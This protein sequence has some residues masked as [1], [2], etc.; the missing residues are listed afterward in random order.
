MFLEMMIVLMNKRESNKLISF[1]LYF[2]VN[3]QTTLLCQMLGL[4]D[5]FAVF[6]GQSSAENPDEINLDDCSD[7][8]DQEIEES[9]TEL[10]TSNT[11]D[12]PTFIHSNTIN[13]ENLL[14]SSSVSQLDPGTPKIVE[15]A[16]PDSQ[17]DDEQVSNRKRMSTDEDN[18]PQ[19]VHT[20]LFIFG[21]TYYMLQCSTIV[22]I[23][24][25]FEGCW[26]CI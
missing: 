4:T 15:K 11:E 25:Y 19:V 14:S 18:K 23:L 16:T 21:C 13:D 17:I 3:P 9:T 26:S 22:E 6:S 1:L 12:Y 7:E 20:L 8:S 5:P 24:F 10:S 2:Q